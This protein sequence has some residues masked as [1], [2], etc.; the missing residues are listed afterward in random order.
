MSRRGKD[1][2]HIGQQRRAVGFDLH[3][4]LQRFFRTLVVA[5]AER[6]DSLIERRDR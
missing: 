3:R 2:G 1:R 5:F 4:R 6:L